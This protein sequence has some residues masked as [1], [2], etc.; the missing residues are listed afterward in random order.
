MVEQKSIVCRPKQRVGDSPPR[1][2]SK[3]KQKSLFTFSSL[4]KR[5]LKQAFELLKETPV[6]FGEQS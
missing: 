3:K 1:T 6:I 4:Y 2:S 5:V